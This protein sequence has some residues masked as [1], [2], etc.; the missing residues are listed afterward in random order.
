MTALPVTSQFCVYNKK[1]SQHRCKKTLS[2]YNLICFFLSSS[3]S[4]LSVHQSLSSNQT[5]KEHIMHCNPLARS[6]RMLLE[7]CTMFA[8]SKWALGVNSW[9]VKVQKESFIG[10]AGNSFSF[11][12]NSSLFSSTLYFFLFRKEF[13]QIFS[14]NFHEIRTDRPTHPYANLHTSGCTYTPKHTNTHTHRNTGEY[15]ISVVCFCHDLKWCAR[16]RVKEKRLVAKSLNEMKCVENN[17]HN[18]QE[19]REKDKGLCM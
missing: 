12:F 18:W 15:D 5:N 17:S 4:P 1:R 3:L 9:A 11:C 14:W 2:A 19:S 13:Q 16:V 6:Y 10:I 7:Y 8:C